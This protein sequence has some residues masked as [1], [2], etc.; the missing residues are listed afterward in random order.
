MMSNKPLTVNSDDPTAKVP[1]SFPHH[2][3]EPKLEHGRCAE[4]MTSDKGETA[5]LGFSG[6]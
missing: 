2:Q 5:V 1:N 3:L 6:L 4:S